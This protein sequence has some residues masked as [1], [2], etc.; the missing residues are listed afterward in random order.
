MSE[1][2]RGANDLELG[3]PSSIVNLSYLFQVERGS[4][5]KSLHPP[6][7]ACDDVPILDFPVVK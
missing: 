3:K 7:A 6:D 4:D 2:L 1:H 5:E